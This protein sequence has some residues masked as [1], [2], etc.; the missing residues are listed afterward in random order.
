MAY[1]DKLNVNGSDYDIQDKRL[2]ESAGTIQITKPVNVGNNFT[3]DSIV[4][5]MSGYSYQNNHIGQN[6]QFTPIYASV[7]KNGNKLTAVIAGTLTPLQAGETFTNI[8]LFILPGTIM[9][10]LYPFSG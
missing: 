1:V 4:E 5:N 6:S 2:P 8:G 7:C 3:A 10:I 9:N